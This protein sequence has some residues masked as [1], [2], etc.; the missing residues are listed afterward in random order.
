MEIPGYKIIDTLGRG[1]MATVYLAIQQSFEREVALKV[2][3]P[4]LLRDP[5]F[6]ERFLR[7]AK[8]VSRLVH[9]NIVTVYD[10]GE[11]DGSHYMSMEYVPG[12]DLKQTRARLTL[13]QG[14]RVVK[15]IARALDYAA[16][17]G[18]VHRDVKPENIMLHEEDGRAVLMDF[19]IARPTGIETGM[20]QTGTA[21]GTPHYMSPEQAKGKAVDARS[22]LYSLGVVLFLL[23]TG[24][25]PFDADSAVAV[26]IKHVSEPVPRLQAA[27]GVFQPIIDKVLA[28][29]PDK[30]YQSGSEL[31]EDLEQ[32]DDEQLRRVDELIE[33]AAKRVEQ[34]DHNADTVISSSI[35]TQRIRNAD[36][37]VEDDD[38]H[39]VSTQHWPQSGRSIPIQSVGKRT[40]TSNPFGSSHWLRNSLWLTLLVALSLFGFRHLLPAPWPEQITHWHHNALDWSK[41]QGLSLSAEQWQ[42]LYD[43]GGAHGNSPE[44]SNQSAT[45]TAPEPKKTPAPEAPRAATTLKAPAVGHADQVLADTQ[46]VLRDN[47][48]L[49]KGTTAAPT[50]MPEAKTEPDASP[51]AQTGPFAGAEKLFAALATDL[52]QAQALADIY[53]AELLNEENRVGAEQ[54]LEQVR[55]FYSDEMQAALDNKD[56]TRMRALQNSVTES[57][58][59][60]AQEAR[61]RKFER[62]LAEAESIADSLS[63]GQQQLARDALSSPSGDN[64]VESFNR[65][66]VL[67]SNNSDAKAGLEAVA[68]RYSQLAISKLQSS[69]WLSAKG[70]VTRGLAVSPGHTGLLAQQKQVARLEAQVKDKQARIDQLIASAKGQASAGNMYGRDG[71]V[72]QYLAVLAL[73]AG[74]REAAKAI[75]S[76]SQKTAEQVANLISQKQFERA[77]E[78]LNAALSLLPDQPILLTAQRDLSAAI[79]ASLP[80]VDSLRVGNSTDII[81]GATQPMVQGVDRSIY[82]GMQFRNFDQTAVVQAILFD[83]SRSIQISQVPVVVSGKQGEKVFRIDRP[84]EG[85]AAGG[86]NIDLV[87]GNKLLLSQRFQIGAQ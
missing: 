5:S 64:A 58:P 52:T 57:F 67:D 74:H 68:N 30:R 20:T 4:E 50:A 10:V 26:G 9:P 21:I 44:P 49:A 33:L 77:Q 18:Y 83:G 39:R 45:V 84:V 6:G 69:D 27:F 22:D 7:E 24:R 40:Q 59:E 78:E 36:D 87:L 16:R 61:L 42:T 29:N 19:G 76:A 8:I 37:L 51:A 14:L 1:G 25:V 43:L 54:G 46:P 85:F 53:R 38:E 62:R 81:F 2:L 63:K 35:D 3:S 41:R 23:V 13:A 11:H 15:D 65:V 48:V 31:V 12:Q 34:A 17:K 73:E 75:S 80:R 82:I 47:G 86:Y 32:I 70:M 55:G 79:D 72:A 66:L 56:L 71:F 60:L 28:K